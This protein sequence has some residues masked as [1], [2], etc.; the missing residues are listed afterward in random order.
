M[1]LVYGVGLFEKG[2]YKSVS[3]E[4]VAWRGMLRRC[5]CPVHQKS[6]PAYHGCTVSEEFLVFQHFAGWAN[7]QPGYGKEGWQLDKDLLAPGNTVY[8]KDTCVFL[9][10]SVNNSLVI[11][12]R[13]DL[14]PGVEKHGPSFRAYWG[15]EGKRYKRGPFETTEEAFNAYRVGKE[16]ALKVVAEKYKDELDSR[17]YQALQTYDVEGRNRC[18]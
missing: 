17:A 18:D 3:P 16:A 15:L 10:A 8:G 12:R 7:A 11:S 9:P 13:G 6:K 4:Y 5:Y 2:A 1:K 14:P